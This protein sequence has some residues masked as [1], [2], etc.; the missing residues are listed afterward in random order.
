MLLADEKLDG[1]RRML[2]VGDRSF[3]DG[4]GQVNW[5]VSTADDGAFSQRRSYCHKPRIRVCQEDSGI[6]ASFL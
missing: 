2:R 1:G 4:K 3:T 5:I 6:G